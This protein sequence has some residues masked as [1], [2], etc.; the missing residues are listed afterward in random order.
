MT[1]RR[2]SSGG[3]VG[4][5]TCAALVAAS[6][7]VAWVG[8][9]YVWHQ[10]RNTRLERDIHAQKME[11]E[12]LAHVSE[13]LDNRI[14]HLRRYDAVLSNAERLNLGLEMPKPDQILPLP[15]PRTDS[16][17]VKS[18]TTRFLVRAK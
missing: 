6:A 18:G 16:D 9:G 11:A 8:I 12:Q 10:N 14:A 4:I 1:Q 15:E 17:P 2:K 5:R 7:L 3:A 13:Q